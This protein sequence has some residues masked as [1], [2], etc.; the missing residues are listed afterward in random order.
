MKRLSLC[1]LSAC[2]T[3]GAVAQGGRAP[4]L[5]IPAPRDFHHRATIWME[6]H[7]A[8]GFGSVDLRPVRVADQP[9]V[10]LAA[11]FVH[12]G[13]RLSAPPA[14]VSIAVKTWADRPRHAGV[15]ELVFALN[16]A[17][18]V[19]ASPLLHQQTDTV[20]GVTETLAVRMPTAIFLRIANAASAEIR[21]GDTRVPLGDDALEALRDFASRMLPAGWERARAA[22]SARVETPMMALRKDYYEPHEVDERAAVSM[23]PPKA[24]YPDLPPQERKVRS[25][26][27]EYVVDTTGRVDLATVRAGSPDEDPRFIEAVR[28]VAGQW[29]FTPARKSGRPV[30]QI[31]HQ[32]LLFEP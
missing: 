23:L 24:R 3:S 21:I 7:A 30:R 15:R 13:E 28:A 14:Q 8:S 20:G 16:D 10:S 12:K 26:L 17:E 6:Y 29:E 27:V 4:A 18:R 22:A 1:I 25:V 11:M 19:A 9:P 5:P 2:L 32:T 31:V